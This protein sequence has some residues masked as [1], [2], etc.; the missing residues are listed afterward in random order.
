M[1]LAIALSAAAASLV[2]LGGLGAAG[3]S[4]NLLLAVVPATLVVVAT[5]Y[6]LH[7]LTRFQQLHPTEDQLSACAQRTREGQAARAKLWAQAMSHTFRPSLLT[8]LTTAVGFGSLGF[9]RI[10]PVR[11]MGIFTALGVLAS[12]WLT[13]TLLPALLVR[14]PAVLPR[15]SGQAGW[16]FERSAKYV[17]LLQQHRWAVSLLGVALMVA[18]GWG[19]TQL[20]VESNVLHF[21]PEDHDLPASYRAIESDFFGLTSLDLWVEGD[22]EAVLSG[23]TVAALQRFF[24]LAAD[25]EL[26]Q[27]GPLLPVQWGGAELAPEDRAQHLRNGLLQNS[28]G[29]AEGAQKYLWMSGDQLGLRATLTYRTTSSQAAF[30]LVERLRSHLAQADL[31]EEL[32]A[33]I[34]GSTPLLVRG[35]VLLLDTQLRS[36]LLALMIVT[37]VLWGAFRSL[38][39]VLVSLLPNVLPIAITLGA[40][41]YAGIPLD[42]AT[43]TVAGIA[44]GLVIDDTIHLLHAYS[45]ARRE[46]APHGAVVEA[47][48]QVG[49]P[50]LTTSLALSL[51]FG[52]FVATS[53]RPTHDFGLL[54]AW[55]GLGA[56]VC[57]LV[58]LPAVLLLARKREES[59]PSPR[60]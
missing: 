56:L 1:V 22:R 17:G 26:A 39:L 35:Q 53:F 5:A 45:V 11:D 25:E 59:R 29:S 2:A 55:T 27:G 16:S 43:V 52:A 4:L 49:R 7:L 38:A 33:R 18:A 20:E 58:L 9:S 44:L 10:P 15:V 6:A 54:I 51:G 34:S 23:R 28:S 42:S 21:F 3:R 24:S 19:V 36:F 60:I 40:M 57:D 31:P 13:F 50:V 48:A 8:A 30:G 12:F 47:L 14:S 32:K 46:R 41:G 37:G